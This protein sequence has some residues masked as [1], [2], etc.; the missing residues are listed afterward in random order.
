MKKLLL[1]GLL[2][3][4]ILAFSGCAST[5]DSMVGL[6]PH[7]TY[8]DGCTYGVNCKKV[9]KENGISGNQL[10][11]PINKTMQSQN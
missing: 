5:I 6:N 11:S 8:T 4:P 2:L 10:P 7:P 9:Y 3:I 1:F